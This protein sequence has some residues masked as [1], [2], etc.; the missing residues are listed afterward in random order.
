MTGTKGGRLAT[1]GG[2]I[3]KRREHSSKKEGTIKK[4]GNKQVRKE[5]TNKS[6]VGTHIAH[7]T[8]ILCPNRLDPSLKGCDL[9]PNQLKNYLAKEKD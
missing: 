2:T 1:K 6:I 9:S 7:V 3:K 5:G 8:V 4:R